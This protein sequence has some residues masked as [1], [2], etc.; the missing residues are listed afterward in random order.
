MNPDAVLKVGGSLSRSAGLEMLCKGIGHLGERCHLLIVPGGG[1]FADQVRA[2]YRRYAL[3]ETAAHQMALLAMDQY[4]YL[5]NQLI[6]ESSL[7]SD[8]DSANR[9]IESGRVAILLSSALIIRTDPLPHSWE[10]TSDS[11]AAWIAR[12]TQ[13][14][15]LV[16][17]KDVDGLLTAGSTSDA[18]KLIAELTVNQLAAHAGGVDAHL[19]RVLAGSNL[20]TWVINGRKPERL[21]ELLETSC[22]TGTRIKG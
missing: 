10:V 2:M 19:S 9:I 12:Q 7:A 8:L 15:R 20:E 13:C 22:T 4:G 1:T 3:S 14:R 16:L 17:L 18:P 11:I 6:S 5:L 21:S